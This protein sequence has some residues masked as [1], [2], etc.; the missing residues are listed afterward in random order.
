MRLLSFV[1]SIT[2]LLLSCN[3][4]EN[5]V[6]SGDWVFIKSTSLKNIQQQ[7]QKMIPPPFPNI[8]DRLGFSILD[9]DSCIFKLGFITFKKDTINNELINIY[10]GNKTNYK[11][12][13]NNIGFYDIIKKKWIYSKIISLKNDTLIL[14]NYDSV[15]TYYIR[16]PKTNYD[17]SKIDK[18]I[19]SSSGCYGSCPISKTLISSDGKV[20]FYGFRFNTKQGIYEANISSVEYNEI[21]NNFMKANILELK[22]R[23]IAN[24]TDDESITITFMKKDSIV[25]SIID[26]GKEAPSELIQA[27]TPIRYLY[28][29]LNLRERQLTK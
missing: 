28:Q 23:Y 2:I 13:K 1:L 24:H 5:K 21:L 18:I 10:L 16:K 6:L 25:K 8:Y 20:E 12:E 14:E 17:L 3:K 27:Y 29:K 9:N 19:V 22:D 4:E 11:V 15:Y 26:Y 7:S